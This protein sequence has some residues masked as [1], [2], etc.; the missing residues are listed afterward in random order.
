M[1]RGSRVFTDESITVKEGEIATATIKMKPTAVT[2][3]QIECL[4]AARTQEEI[5]MCL[6]REQKSLVAHA[7][8]DMSAY[9][10]TLDVQV[11]SPALR[12][13]VASPTRGWNVGAS[14]L[15]DVVTAASPDI[16]STASRHFRDV[17]HDVALTGGYKPGNFGAQISG[18][19]ST[20]YD[21]ISRSIGITGLADLRDKSISPALGYSF[22]SNTIGRA[23][24]DYDVFSHDFAVHDV[25]AS[26]TFILSPLALL[27]VGAELQ[28]EVGD[29]SKPYRYV[30]IFEP[31]VTVPVGA[32]PDE[33]NARRLPAK[34]LEQLPLDRQRLALT[35]RYVRR[36]GSSTLRID[37]RLYRDTWD[38]TATTTDVRWLVD[39]GRLRVG[40]NLHFHAQTPARFYRRIY[41]ALLDAD[42]FAQLP[43]FRTTDRELGPMFGLTGG[44]TLRVRLTEEQRK[45]QLAVYGSG[46][47][48]YNHYLDALYV[49]DRLA[50]YGTLGVEGD[51]E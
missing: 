43:V 4:M 5:L 13:S 41:P 30:P 21:Y 6:P 24:T 38:I 40:P 51:F 1:L 22:T 25:S 14:Y 10:D 15:V 16:V 39:V 23:G 42:G 9:A 34:L 20:E 36:I 33:V 28:L 2:P 19:Y 32:S 45:I 27:A 44:A 48:L 7:A 12:A 29:Q 8:L 31:G 47:A 17:R 11:L 18:N 26:S 46:S 37:E 49:T 35:G 50:G 3:G